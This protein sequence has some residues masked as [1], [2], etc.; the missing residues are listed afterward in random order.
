MSNEVSYGELLRFFKEKKSPEKVVALM[1]DKDLVNA[2]LAWRSVIVTFKDQNLMC[3]TSV[4]KEE[5]QQW[6]WLWANVSFDMQK[7]GIV[8]DLRVQSVS[9]Y[10]ERLKGLRLIFPD[11]STDIY[12]NQYLGSLIMKTLKK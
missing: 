11:G 9:N 12:A 1:N 10:F 8:A 7:F 5:N 3:D 6:E 4:Y 2:L